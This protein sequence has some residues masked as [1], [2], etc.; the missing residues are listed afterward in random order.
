MDALWVPQFYV[1]IIFYRGKK[2]QFD[3]EKNEINDLLEVL[4]SILA[5]ILGLLEM[6]LKLRVSIVWFEK[7]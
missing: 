7:M 4:N 2:I 3:S 6:V 1:F 5:W